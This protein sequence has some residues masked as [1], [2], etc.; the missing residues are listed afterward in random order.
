MLMPVAEIAKVFAVPELFM[1][2]V[3]HS[4]GAIV[5]RGGVEYIPFL[6]AVKFLRCPADVVTQMCRGQEWLMVEADIKK[7]YG[8]YYGDCPESFHRIAGE[9]AF[10]PD[11]LVPVYRVSPFV[12]FVMKSTEERLAFLE[13]PNVNRPRNKTA[14]PKVRGGNR[15]PRKNYSPRGKRLLKPE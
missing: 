13:G 6:S 7:V 14:S 1:R 8:S 4:E 5:N 10:K 9:P 15:L 2:R 11:S 12:E 3:A